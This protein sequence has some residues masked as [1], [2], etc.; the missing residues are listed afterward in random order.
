MIVLCGIQQQGIDIAYFLRQKGILVDC[1][2]TINEETAKKENASGWVSYEEV[3]TALG[4][5]V[6]YAK[7]YSLREDLD[8]F[9]RR[10]FGTLLLGGWQR[11]IPGSVLSTL[12]FGGIGQHGSS[13]Y[14]PLGRGRSP[15]NWA[16]ILGRR[17]LVWN[18][19][20]LT[21]GVDDGD[22]LATTVF[23]INEWDDCNTLYKKVAVVV[24]HML[25]DAIIKLERGDWT[26]VEQ[27][28]EPS[29]YSK[30]GWEDGRI[31]WDNN[32]IKQ[33]YN[34]VRAVTKPYPGSWTKKG[35]KIITIWKAQ[36]WDSYLP[37]YTSA[38]PGQI[39]EIFEDGTY[40]V[41]CLDGLL[42]ITESTDSHP[43]V[44]DTYA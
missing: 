15:L 35:D 18:L 8:F 2:V 44:G 27:E 42:L 33:T 41:A 17:R 20:R 25:P 43:R 29:Y 13:E 24:K 22:I 32:S 31:F 28:G 1:F 10:N 19:F 14:L 9:E 12:K 37:F 39:V 34:L 16:L 21:P 30:R 36:P 38:K 6:Y 11:L 7:S 3:A 4:A 40:V 5:E 26:G 23:E